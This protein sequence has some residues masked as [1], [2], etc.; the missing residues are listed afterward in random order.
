MFSVLITDIGTHV[1]ASGE[2]SVEF[3]TDG[4]FLLVFIR[5]WR[6]EQ[7]CRVFLKRT[8]RLQGQTS[9]EICLLSYLMAAISTKPAL[10]S[11]TGCSART[12]E[13]LDQSPYS[14]YGVQ[15]PPR[16]EELNLHQ[17]MHKKRGSVFG[18]I[19]FFSVLKY[20][21]VS[22]GGCVELDW[23]LLSPELSRIRDF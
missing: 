14:P 16:F 3:A 8:S 17:L 22:L 15:S 21:V 12:I 11:C 19:N 23:V 2:Y 1:N 18:K 20:L 9:A 4:A 13:L 5:F 7:L 10:V 6:A